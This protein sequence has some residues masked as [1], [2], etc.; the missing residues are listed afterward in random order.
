VHHQAGK[1]DEAARSHVAIDRV[2]KT[3][4]IDWA[5]AGE[6]RIPD[7]KSASVGVHGVGVAGIE[8]VDEAR[9]RADMTV[10][11][12]VVAIAVHVG[13][14]MVGDGGRMIERAPKEFKRSFVQ[15]GCFRATPTIGVMH[16][17]ST[18]GTPVA[19][20]VGGLPYPFQNTLC[21]ARVVKIGIGESRGMQNP[22]KRI[23]RLPI[24][25]NGNGPVTNMHNASHRFLAGGRA[26]R[27]LG[28]N[29]NFKHAFR[30]AHN[31]FPAWQAVNSSQGKNKCNATGD[32]QGVGARCYT[33]TVSHTLLVP[34]YI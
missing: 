17:C 1:H 12:A 31:I 24:G 19:L 29:R 26:S 4:F 6:P 32:R 10:R 25:P 21:Q 33:V 23:E 15:Q 28:G 2:S 20:C 7:A 5:T 13:P 22:I 18:G 14:S 9:G 3:A 16:L 34:R 8:K 27:R 11:H 30:I